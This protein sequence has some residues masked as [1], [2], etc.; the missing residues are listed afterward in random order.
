MGASPGRGSTARAQAQLREGFVFTGASPVTETG[1]SL[2]VGAPV[3]NS[4]NVALMNDV[5]QRLRAQWYGTLPSDDQLT[6]GALRGMVNSL[7]DP[8]TTY[9][10]PQYAG[11]LNEDMARQFEGIGATLKQTTSGAIQILR[12]NNE[13]R[14]NGVDAAGRP[15]G[16]WDALAIAMR[17]FGRFGT[18]SNDR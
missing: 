10:E 2:G 18:S 15:T 17:L 5:L 1:V 12:G 14:R 7:G 4:L 3:T 8:F 9:V 16:A 11:S 13:S 6:N